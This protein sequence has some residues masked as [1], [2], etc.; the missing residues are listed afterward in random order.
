[1]N[2]TCN[3]LQ[4]MHSYFYLVSLSYFSNFILISTSIFY[5]TDTTNNGYSLYTNNLAKFIYSQNN[6]NL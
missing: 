2:L 5:E 4:Q 3:L 1:M 6:F